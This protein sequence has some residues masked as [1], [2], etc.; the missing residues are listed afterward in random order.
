MK[1]T[2]WMI[3]AL[4]L[5]ASPSTVL[6]QEPGDGFRVTMVSVGSGESP[7]ASGLTATVD[8]MNEDKILVEITAQQEQAWFMVGKEFALGKAT[9]TAAGTVGH[10][11]GAPWVA[12]YLYLS[13]PVVE[14]KGQKVSVSVLE[15]P[16]FF[17]GRE[18][19]E[20][21][22]DNVPNVE[23]M[24]VGWFTMGQVS[25]GGFGLTYTYLNF[26]NDQTNLLPG[27]SYTRK[28]R[29]DLEATGSV[30]W[31]SNGEKA[32]Y[33]IGATWRPGK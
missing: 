23:R 28:I 21:R 32:M 13:V 30:T 24:M 33:Y 4:A 20:W 7:I 1:K 31:D 27:V 17:I 3:L 12:P 15:W 9:F 8:L 6:A 29:S 11:Q 25:V 18:P 22:N 26:M 2:N 5:L 16:G 19:E 10:F 14:V